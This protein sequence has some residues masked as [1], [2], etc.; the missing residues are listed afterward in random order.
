M[1]ILFS[2]CIFNF[3]RSIQNFS[4]CRQT[5][6][7]FHWQYIVLSNDSFHLLKQFLIIRVIITIYLYSLRTSVWNITSEISQ[8]TEQSIMPKVAILY[9]IQTNN[10][11]TNILVG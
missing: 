6:T 1:N 11:L 8:M 10:W 5:T 7:I 2:D 4:L 9:S 3:S